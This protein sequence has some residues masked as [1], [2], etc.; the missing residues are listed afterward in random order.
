MELQINKPRFAKNPHEDKI[1]RAITTEVSLFMANTTK[2][3]APIMIVKALLYVGLFIIG[4]AGIITAETTST[5]FISYAVTGISLVLL[6]LNFAHD[7]AHGALLKSKTAN[8]AVYE[9]LFTL[10]GING[11]LWKKRHTH[12]HHNYPNTEGY[13]V[14]IELGS[15]VHLS[16]AESPKNHHSVQHIYAPLLYGIYTLYW[17]FYKDFVLFF[18]KH[19]ANLTFKKHSTK[20][21]VKLFGGKLLYLTY[22]FIIPLLVTPFSVG[23]ITLV[24]LL[25]HFAASWLLLFTFLITHHVENTQ[26]FSEHENV[27][28]S[29]SWL[30]H[31]VQSSNDFH[32]CNTV[33]NFVFGGFNCHVAHHLFPNVSH[34][35]YPE[36]SRII[37]R[38]LYS[39]GI[40]P[41]KTTFLGGV[42]SHIKLLKK[43][44]HQHNATSI[45]YVKI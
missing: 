3:N 6:G 34:V 40:T 20:E 1:F 33:A 4:Y 31:Q 12:S 8:N 32:A 5:L 21:Y 28:T 17:V 29:S 39:N 13:D 11:Y 15:I 44:G 37:Y 16:V 23:Q 38:H 2:S 24:F 25:F 42:L 10:M 35:H 43:L 45:S 7:C 19:H 41:N 26:Y 14:D 9:S 36:I 27:L 30:M 22:I 18:K